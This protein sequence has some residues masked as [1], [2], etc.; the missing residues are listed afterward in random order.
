VTNLTARTDLLGAVARIRPLLEREA[1]SAEAERRLTSTAYQAMV[2]AELFG[3]MAPRAY[4]GLELPI[5][6]TMDVWEAVARIDSAAAWNLV[7]NQSIAA[8][9]AWLPDEGAQELFADGPTTLAGALFPPGAARR[10]EGGWTIT[11]RVP[12]A[13]GCHN[14]TWLGLPAV[15]VGDDGEPKL[16]P[17]TGQPT[18]FGAFFRRDDADVLDTWHTVGMRGTGSADISVTD[19]YVPDRR[20]LAV[21]PLSNPAPGFEGPLYRMMPWPAI[22]GEATVSVGVAAAALDAAVQLV[23]TKTPAYQATPLRDQQLAQHLAGRA[24]ARVNAARDTLH[25]AAQASYD[26]AAT[27]Q[28]LSWDAKIR[29]Q[30]AVCF[31]AEACAEAVRLVDDLVGSSSI[32]LGQPFER[33]FRDAHTLLQHASKSNPRYA[34]A[35]RLLFGLDNDWVWLSF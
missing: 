35:G 32:R 1:A 30:V 31:A 18:P 7:M 8:F 5:V 13:S 12:F 33:H 24:M 27:G 4:G 6:D 2:D 29:L 14:A 26:E 22:L 3:M 34:S 20:T 25:C 9:A 15:E 19:L 17:V 16:D 21:G 23:A 11:G 28:L 10:S